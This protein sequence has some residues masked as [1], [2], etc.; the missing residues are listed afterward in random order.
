MEKTHYIVCVQVV[1]RRAI[2][3]IP[4]FPAYSALIKH[5]KPH[6]EK[7]LGFLF[8]FSKTMKDVHLNVYPCTMETS[9][10]EVRKIGPLVV[11]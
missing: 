2:K 5:T 6:I 10:E 8:I 7:L 9:C 11:S 1:N 4:V 3:S